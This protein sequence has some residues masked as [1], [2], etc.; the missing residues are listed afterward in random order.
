METNTKQNDDTNRDLMSSWLVFL[1]GHKQKQEDLDTYSQIENILKEL[2]EK[3]T[4][5]DY[6]SEDEKHLLTIFSSELIKLIL[7]N[8][9]QSLKQEEILKLYMDILSN[10]SANPK[11]LPLFEQCVSIFSDDHLFYKNYDKDA[12]ENFL[13][14]VYQNLKVTFGGVSL[15]QVMRSIIYLRTQIATFIEM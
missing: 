12:S 10:H 11:L 3:D 2:F 13:E 5:T 6:E 1:K 15:S 9:D 4:F 7:I 8:R 14:L